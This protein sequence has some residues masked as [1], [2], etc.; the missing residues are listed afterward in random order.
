MTAFDE[1]YI[2]SRIQW[3]AGVAPNARRGPR[4]GIQANLPPLKP[5]D[6]PVGV[7]RDFRVAGA[8][9]VYVA[10]V[11]QRLRD[12]IIARYRAFNEAEAAPAVAGFEEKRAAVMR[13]AVLR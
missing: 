8:R 1:E 2:A 6:K 12:Q 13:A 7:A 10:V 5:G 11:T 4:W 3:S 9:R